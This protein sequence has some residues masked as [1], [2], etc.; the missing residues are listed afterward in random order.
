[1]NQLSKFRLLN[2]FVLVEPEPRELVVNG[3]HV[4]ESWADKTDMGYIRAVGSKLSEPLKIGDR[5]FI[6]RM[7]NTEIELDDKKYK[8]VRTDDVWATV[9]K[10]DV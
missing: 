10:S 6:Q 2:D 5:V 1:M 4:P 8:I 7:G 9:N 3:I